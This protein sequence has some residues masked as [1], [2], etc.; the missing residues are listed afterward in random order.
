M[1]HVAFGAGSLEEFHAE[2]MLAAS[3]GNFQGCGHGLLVEA[4]HADFVDDAFSIITD[5]G[6]S[7]MHCFISLEGEFGQV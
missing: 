4:H 5:T 6:A 7:I 2:S 3:A 1:H